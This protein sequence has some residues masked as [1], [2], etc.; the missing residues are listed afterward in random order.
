M[1]RLQYLPEPGSRVWRN[2]S[3][4]MHPQGRSN[5]EASARALKAQERWHDWRIV[6]E[7]VL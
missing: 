3:L 1:L 7:K 4:Q 5:M 6:E 2:S